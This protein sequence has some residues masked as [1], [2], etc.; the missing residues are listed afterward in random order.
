MRTQPKTLSDDKYILAMHRAEKILARRHLHNFVRHTF[1]AY[2]ESWFHKSLCDR[3]EVFFENVKLG[4]RPRLIISAPRRH[5]KTI[6]TSI[7]FPAWVLGQNPDFEISCCAYDQD[8]ANRNS[9]KCRTLIRSASFKELYPNYELDSEL[10]S[11]WTLLGH[12]GGYQAVGVGGGLTGKGS[13]ILIIDDWVKNRQEA[14]SP[15]EQERV[16]EWWKSVAFPTLHPIG[17]VLVIG[18]RWHLDD[19]IGKILDDEEDC[20]TPWER[21]T[22]RA[23][24][25]ANDS[26]AVPEDPREPGEALDIHRYPIPILDDIQRVVKDE[27]LPQY[28]QRPQ[29]MVGKCYFTSSQ[30]DPPDKALQRWEASVITPK[31]GMVFEIRQQQQYEFRED[32]LEFLRLWEGPIQGFCY[33]AG[34]DIAEGKPIGSKGESDS[35]VIRVMRRGI[36][37]EVLKEIGA[38]IPQ[39]IGKINKPTLVAMY[40]GNPDTDIL[41]NYI[42]HLGF[43]Y[44]WAEVL[45]ER[46]AVGVGVVDTLKRIY[47]NDLILHAVKLAENTEQ[48]SQ[49]LG[50]QTG[51]SNKHELLSGLKAALRDDKFDNPDAESHIEYRH[52]VNLGG[53]LGGA[54]G[55]NDDIVMADALMWKAH[56]LTP[57]GRPKNMKTTRRARPMRSMDS[58]TGY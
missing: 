31:R 54:P 28:Q 35:S 34:V 50:Y 45:P 3:L 19:L 10:V 46:N 41:A 48:E 49:K 32:D 20:G 33:S 15:V 58:E 16:H 26:E 5:G 36:S 4:K 39:L 21:L 8:L 44:N 9:R 29:M 12:E 24:S 40:R 13:H 42:A 25:E 14:D 53:S 51:P 7:H 18:T 6:I 23:Y 57:L 2:S 38:S 11:H 52:F 47:P 1:G 55:W 43:W 27:W 30:D 17:G 56:T 22:Y 37:D